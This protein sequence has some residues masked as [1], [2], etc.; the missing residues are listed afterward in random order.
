MEIW[1]GNGRR[2]RGQQSAHKAQRHA[3]VMLVYEFQAVVCAI[4]VPGYLVEQQRHAERCPSRLLAALVAIVLL[5]D[6]LQLVE[7]RLGGCIW[8]FARPNGFNGVR[9]RGAAVRVKRGALRGR[10]H[11]PA[12]CDAHVEFLAARVDAGEPC[13]HQAI[14]EG[15]VEDFGVEFEAGRRHCVLQSCCRAVIE[16]LEV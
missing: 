11:E 14:V 5:G 6:A 13:L 7:E 1:S 16:W 12:L 9:K 10:L 4:Q 3:I 15:A 2:R 8:E